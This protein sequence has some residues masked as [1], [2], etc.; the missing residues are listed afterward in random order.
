MCDPNLA[1]RSLPTRVTWQTC[2]HRNP[3]CPSLPVLPLGPGNHRMC[4]RGSSHTAPPSSVPSRLAPLE[5]TLKGIRGLYLRSHTN[6]CTLHC[7]Q[8]DTHPAHPDPSNH[9]NSR[10]PDL[11]VGK[12]IL[13]SAS[14]DGA[15]VRG[16]S[17]PRQNVLS[18]APSCRRP[19]HGRRTNS[20]ES[21]GCGP[22]CEPV[23][24]CL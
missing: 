20:P 17:N 2:G 7:C 4:E 3:L 15:L 14:P 18:G 19:R 6:C 21:W 9:E 10:P 13:C 23:F 11:L 1:V 8:H 24:P 22:C 5:V 12:K 16:G